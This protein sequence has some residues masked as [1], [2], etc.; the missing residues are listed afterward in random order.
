MP[1]ATPAFLDFQPNQILTGPVSWPNTGTGG[2]SFDLDTV[3]GTSS[4]ITRVLDGP[5]GNR[6]V[7]NSNASN[8]DDAALKTTAN[9]T[10]TATQFTF[11]VFA[12][13]STAP[14]VLFGGI[15]DTRAGIS[16]RKVLFHTPVTLGNIWRTGT[17]NNPWTDQPY[18]TGRCVFGGR[19]D[20]VGNLVDFRMENELGQGLDMRDVSVAVSAD[21]TNFGT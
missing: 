19:L 18:I 5:T 12:E 3:V 13:F 20:S 11:V 21:F 6:T 4:D 7:V 14:H 8:N 16:G 10:I 15:F 17:G 2:A 9:A 1:I